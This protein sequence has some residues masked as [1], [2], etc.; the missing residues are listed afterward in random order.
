MHLAGLVEVTDQ[1]H[2]L[3]PA[4]GA[5]VVDVQTALERNDGVPAAGHAHDVGMMPA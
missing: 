1:L 4:P 2:A 3:H 5:D